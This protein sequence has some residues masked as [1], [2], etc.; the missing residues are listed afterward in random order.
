L[1]SI[2]SLPAKTNPSLFE[3]EEERN[4]RVLMMKRKKLRKE[5]E[6]GIVAIEY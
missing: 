1:L 6:K 3:E 5:E 4:K 2:F